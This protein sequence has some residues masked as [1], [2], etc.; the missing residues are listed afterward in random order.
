VKDLPNITLSQDLLESDEIDYMVNG[1][2]KVVLFYSLRLLVSTVVET[3]IILDRSLFIKEKVEES[4]VKIVPI[5]D[6]FISP[7][8]LAIVAE[9]NVPS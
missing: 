3:L 6:P 2:Y 4:T 1:W 9:K 7:R 8:N 5:F